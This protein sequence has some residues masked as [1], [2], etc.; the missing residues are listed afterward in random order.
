M[1][2]RG[3]GGQ[4]GE[5]GVGELG[6]RALLKRIGA[7]ERAAL[8][9]LFER[10]AGPVFRLAERRLGDAKIAEEVVVDVFCEIWRNAE[11]FQG[12]CTASTWVF[13]ITHFKCVAPDRHRSREATVVPLASG[14]RARPRGHTRR[15]G[16]RRGRS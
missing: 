12:Q 3:G 9:N 1:Q 10:Y 6:E 7:R 5:L 4:N 11:R 14:A 8:G 13:G 16:P 15:P 2:Q